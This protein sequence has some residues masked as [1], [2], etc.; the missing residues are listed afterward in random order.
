MLGG[1]KKRVLLLGTLVLIA[2]LPVLIVKFKSSDEV[3]V[4]EGR[5]LD[6]WIGEWYSGTNAEQASAAISAMGTNAI[7]SLLK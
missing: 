4:Y 5:R 7:P 3:P 6:A 2:V 1:Q